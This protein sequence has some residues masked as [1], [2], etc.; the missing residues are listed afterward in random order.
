MR[1]NIMNALLVY[2]EFL[3]TFWSWKHLL[4]FV[5]KKSAFPPLGLLT[6]AAMLPQ[7][8]NK[9]LVD[10]NVTELTD[11]DIQWADYVFVGAMKTQS[12][13]AKEVIYRCAT[14]GKP[15]ILGGPIL[16]TGYEEFEQVSHI[17]IGEAE[18]IL[19]DFLADLEN[20]SA[21]RVYKAKKFPDI[22]TSPIPLWELINPKDYASGLIQWSRGCPYKCEFCDIDSLNG[23]VPRV[24][25]VNQFLAELDAMYQAGFRG[26]MLVADDNFIGN[27]SKTRIMLP[28]LAKWQEER[29]YPFNF[30]IEAPITIADMPKLMGSMV[31]AHI[32]KVFSGIE[33]PNT[34]SLVECAKIQNLN[35]ILVA[36]VNR[37][38]EAGL[39][40]M[41]GFI[42]G[43]DNDP[44]ATFAK[45]MIAFIQNSGIVIAMVGVLQ[46]P[47]GTK[48]YVRL[49]GEG[50][51]LEQASGNNTDCYP[52]FVPVMP[53]ETLVAGYKKII[54]TIY[55]PKECY[56][57]ICTFLKKYN[58][59]KRVKTKISKENRMA[60]LRSVW[61]IGIL[62][63]WKTK[64]YYW[65]TIFTVLTKH[66]SA[67]AEAV[68][69]QIY[70]AGHFQKIAEAIEES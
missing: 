53:I 14:L 6:V 50:R 4:K 21:K 48:L 19:H 49:Q 46:A 25:S 63:S 10:L 11:A 64:W 44:P 65:R 54:A 28:E 36:D 34:A 20:G 56:K 29:G 51:L 8:W 55:S 60:F 15:I 2:P 3:T 70:V 1:R 52:N 40:P 42:V 17:L 41:S 7:K 5:A 9:K 35:R 32:G 39:T 22:C 37:I 57:R 47:L 30:T 67:F 66:R 24:K 45:D 13:S 31:A 27:I 43:F 68:T 18:D 62:G 58:P 69:M 26:A 12:A 38:Q 16:Q 59:S 23:R 33:T 61:Y